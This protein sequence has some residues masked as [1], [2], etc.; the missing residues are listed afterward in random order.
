MWGI[1]KVIKR[2][3]APHFKFKNLQHVPR[4]KGGLKKRAARRRGKQ[5]DAELEQYVLTQ[6][7]PKRTCKET[8]LVLAK[9]DEMGLKLTNAQLYVANEGLNMCAFIDLVALRTET[10]TPVVIEIKRGCHYKLCSTLNGSLKF[11]EPHVTDCLQNQHQMQALLGK[12]LYEKNHGKCECCLIYVDES[13]CE[14]IPE[15]Q[16]V[17]SVSAEALQTIAKMKKTKKRKR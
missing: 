8:H 7:T 14:F 12:M 4:N 13:N 6:T 2:A 15:S 5:I 17:V 3:F 9:L 10:N 16:F 1:T 11:H